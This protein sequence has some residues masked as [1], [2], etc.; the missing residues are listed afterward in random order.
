MR[1][2]FSLVVC[3]LLAATALGQ[4][5][6]SPNSAE[7]HHA[8]VDQRGDHAMGF[9]HEKTTHHFRLFKDGGAIEVTANDPADVETRDT[10]RMH[11]T[12]IAKMFAAG[13]FKVPMFIHDSDP[14]GAK[15]MAELREQIHYQFQETES[16]GKIRISTA[17]PRAL[18]AVHSFLECQ[19]KDHQTGD[20][21]DV[22]SGPHEK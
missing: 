8:G 18:D 4:E 6:K 5:T 22:A 21:L 7:E 9:S 1:M 14:P 19:S 10:I 2:M 17:N 16:G 3:L 13:N 15:V 12:H 20:P 11:L